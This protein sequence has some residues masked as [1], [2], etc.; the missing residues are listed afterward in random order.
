ME[1]GIGNNVSLPF[2]PANEFVSFSDPRKAYLSQHRALQEPLTLPSTMLPEL[3]KKGTPSAVP[4]AQSRTAD[5]NLFVR[6]S[7][8]FHRLKVGEWGVPLF[9]LLTPPWFNS[10][11]G[12]LW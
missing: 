3:Q 10:T 1:M 9:P 4:S 2:L 6:L 7:I 8:Y 5:P 12:D 11:Q